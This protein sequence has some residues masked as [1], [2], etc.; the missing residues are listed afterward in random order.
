MIFGKTKIGRDC[1]VQPNVI[2]GLPSKKLLDVPAEKLPG[3]IL[4]GNCIIRSGTVIYSNTT[5][6][7][8]FKTGHNVLIREDT[9]IGNNVLV[10]TNSIIENKCNIGNNVS[11]QSN[12]Y[13]PTNTKIGDFA[14][15]GPNACL[16]ND[17]YPIR[18]KSKLKGPT[19][20]KG[21]SIGAN[22]TILPNIRIGEGS[23]VAA[24]AVVTKNIKPWKLAIGVPAR[25]LNI[26]KKLK[27]LNK[28]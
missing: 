27:K 23:I 6:G 20:E 16:T 21:V 7:N 11:I 9:E 10:G 2:I 4:G 1:I 17:K 14:F 25:E 13:I 26:P 12:V 24:G 22:A 19:I 8:K 15:L 18:I 5:I 3:A 28:I